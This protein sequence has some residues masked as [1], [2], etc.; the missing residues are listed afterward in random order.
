LEWH[1]LGIYVDFHGEDLEDIAG[2]NFG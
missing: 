1:V 2:E